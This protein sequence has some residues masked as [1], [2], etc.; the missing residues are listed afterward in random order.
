[1]KINTGKV[2]MTLKGEPYQADGQDLTVGHVLAEA[3]AG[4]DA[5]G[6][7]KLFILA[8][9]CYGAQEVE[10]DEVDLGLTKKAVEACK[11]YNNLIVGQALLALEASA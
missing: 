5:G 7:M 9:K 8:Q 1:M 6:K 11:T 10:M 4:L 3:L 2:L